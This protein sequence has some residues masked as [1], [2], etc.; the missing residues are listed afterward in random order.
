MGHDIIKLQEMID[1]S[2]I[3]FEKSDYETAQHNCLHLIEL[4]SSVPNVNSSEFV[5][6][7]KIKCMAHR[8]LSSVLGKRGNVKDALVHAQTSQIIS[9]I[10]NDKNEEAASLHNIGTINYYL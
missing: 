3:A 2:S 1:A 9:R 4:L 10:I 5:E 6:L 8:M 7:V